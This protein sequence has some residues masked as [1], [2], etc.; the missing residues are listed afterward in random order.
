MGARRA[1]LAAALL[2]STGSL[3]T[4][5]PEWIAR[6]KPGVVVVGSFAETDS[7]RFQFRGSGFAVGD[8]LSV[9]TAAH[10]LPDP[11]QLSNRAGCRARLCLEIPPSRAGRA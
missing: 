6:L 2:A 1:L 10:V 11:A 7:P 5:L 8:G 4:G 3:A 9:V